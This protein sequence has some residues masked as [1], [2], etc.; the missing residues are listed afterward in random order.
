MISNTQIPIECTGD[1]PIDSSL[2]DQ[3]KLLHEKLRG[4]KLYKIFNSNDSHNHYFYKDGL[5]VLHSTFNPN[6]KCGYGGLYFAQEGNILRFL[7]WGT[8]YRQ[9]YLHNDSRICQVNYKYKTD[10]LFLGKRKKIDFTFFQKQ[11]S[12][13]PSNWISDCKDQN[14][15]DFFNFLKLL[16]ENVPSIDTY[17]K[18]LQYICSGDIYSNHIYQKRY[19]WLV[20]VKKNYCYKDKL[21]RDVMNNLLI[22]VYNNVSYINPIIKNL[23]N[24]IIDRL[25]QKNP[26]SIVFVKNPTEKQ[27]KIAYEK[28]PSILRKIELYQE[29]MVNHIIKE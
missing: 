27:L 29:E 23:P 17:K 4:K 10:K 22:N 25:I 21:Y 28:F 5:N 1:Y 26:Y 12:F 18:V 19:Q 11:L 14:F 8:Y 9:V 16:H 15:L 24:D 13:Y 20:Y 6:P 7:W 3:S 2:D